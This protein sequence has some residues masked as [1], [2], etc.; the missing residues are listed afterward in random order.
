[1]TTTMGKM[2]HSI[3]AK[4][5]FFNICLLCLCCIM[6]LL[7]IFTRQ[8][9]VFSKFEHN[10][11]V[12]KHDF[13]YCYSKSHLSNSDLITMKKEWQLSLIL[14]KFV[15]TFQF[16]KFELSVEFL[17]GEKLAELPDEIICKVQNFWKYA[18]GFIYQGTKF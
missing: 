7:C 6:Y 10:Q 13:H 18:R 2:L 8:W 11:T 4:L 16:E 3:T 15:I 5:S 17:Y 9:I 1:M 12:I 14:A